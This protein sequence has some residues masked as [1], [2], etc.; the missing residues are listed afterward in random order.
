MQTPRCYPVHSNYI[1]PL[2]CTTFGCA[3]CLVYL[4]N[5][6]VEL[7]VRCRVLSFLTR[8]PLAQ[9]QSWDQ[10]GTNEVILH[11]I[12]TI[13]RYQTTTK[14]KAET[15]HF[16]YSERVL[17]KISSTMDQ[18][19]A[20]VLHLSFLSVSCHVPGQISWPICWHQL[21]GHVLLFLY[22][23]P[24]C[25]FNFFQYLFMIWEWYQRSCSDMQIL[26]QLIKFTGFLNNT[27]PRLTGKIEELY[28]DFRL[29]INVLSLIRNTS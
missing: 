27:Y 28:C 23:C 8:L 3:L 18:H 29:R 17:C 6:F 14:H 13:V 10:P 12:V 15:V 4:C 21:K 20:N 11:H 26:V 9:G 22:C 5:L 7:Y 24:Y 1:P 2:I 16:I 19:D 25:Q